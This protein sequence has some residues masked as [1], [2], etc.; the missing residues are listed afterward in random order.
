MVHLAVGREASQEVVRADFRVVL[1]VEEVRAVREQVQAEVR[2]VHLPLAAVVLVAVQAV[3]RAGRVVVAPAVLA[4]QAVAQVVVLAA[5]VLADAAVQVPVVR[6]A[7]LL[8]EFTVQSRFSGISI[9]TCRS[10]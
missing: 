7:C 3:D 2:A 6:G 10:S 8:A 4:V 1:E 9:C 5:V